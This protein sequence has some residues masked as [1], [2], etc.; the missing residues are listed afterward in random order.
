MSVRAFDDDTRTRCSRMASGVRQRFLN[1]AEAGYFDVVRDAS[2]F[3]VSDDF[4]NDAAAG[5]ITADV[6]AKRSRQTKI[7]EQRRP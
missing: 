2:Q 3:C 6:P 4:C 5:R 7:V 1:N